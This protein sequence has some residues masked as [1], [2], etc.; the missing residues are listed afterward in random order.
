MAP[1]GEM[2][3]GGRGVRGELG[4]DAF[5]SSAKKKKNTRHTLNIK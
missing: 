2:H 1:T 5:F 4:K 3:K